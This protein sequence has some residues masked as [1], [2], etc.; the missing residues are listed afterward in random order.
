[1][2]LAFLQVLFINIYR[3]DVNIMKFI[4]EINPS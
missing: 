3:Y 4:F 2:E 1:V